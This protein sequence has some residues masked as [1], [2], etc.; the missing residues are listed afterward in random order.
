[1]VSIN[2]HTIKFNDHIKE[3]L[4]QLHARGGTTH[5]L[6]SNLFKAYKVVKDKEF[7]KYIKD[8]KKEYDEGKDINPS[9]LM[10]LAANKFKT[11]KQEVVA[12][13]VT[14]SAQQKG[15]K[16]NFEP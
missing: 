10:P 4:Q 11:M 16:W 1:M 3:L 2:S 5:D 13:N 14:V 12:E 9:Q 8:K 15:D 7:T 6:L